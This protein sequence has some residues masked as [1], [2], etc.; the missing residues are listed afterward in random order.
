[1]SPWVKFQRGLPQVDTMCPSSE[2]QFVSIACAD[3]NEYLSQM[4]RVGMNSQLAMNA[5]G[6]QPAG[7]R[8]PNGRVFLGNTCSFLACL[9]FPPP[10]PPPRRRKKKVGGGPNQRSMNRNINLN[11][12]HRPNLASACGYVYGNLSFRARW[13]YGWL[14]TGLVGLR[15]TLGG[16]RVA[17]QR[18]KRSLEWVGFLIPIRTPQ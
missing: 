10:P 3:K 15:L 2:Y 11:L 14:G 8:T 7:R 1:M 13:V 18:H 4:S 6:A 5:S 17:L 9:V 16:C 12:Q